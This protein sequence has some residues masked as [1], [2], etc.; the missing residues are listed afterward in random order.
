MNPVFKLACPLALAIA[1]ALPS[2]PAH[3]QFGGDQMKQFAPMIGMMKKKMGRKHYGHLMHTVGPMM[4]R[5]M[6]QGGGGG[7]F[8]GLGGGSLGSLGGGGLGGMGDLSGLIGSY[9]FG[10]I[11]SGRSGGAAHY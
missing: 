9:G 4:A 8:G 5:M 10:G 3:A 1:L 11:G 2:V 6:Q 7:G